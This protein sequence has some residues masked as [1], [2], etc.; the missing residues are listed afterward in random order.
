MLPPKPR[1]FASYRFSQA[2]PFQL[3][4]LLVS[5]L[6]VQIPASDRYLGGRLPPPPFSLV[7][8]D[9]TSLFRLQRAVDPRL[10]NHCSCQTPFGKSPKRP[11]PT[12]RPVIAHLSMIRQCATHSIRVDISGR[13][14][15]APPFTW[16]AKLSQK[17]GD[18]EYQVQ[19]T[20]RD[21]K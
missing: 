11:R 17:S 9:S 5:W 6:L 20:N 15:L 10:R 13:K 21:E 19:I 4:V 14:V 16:A 7:A 3:P 12:P 18:R 8:L 2:S 1:T